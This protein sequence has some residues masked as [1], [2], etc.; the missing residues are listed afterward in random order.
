MG[1]DLFYLS[2]FCPWVSGSSSSSRACCVMYS[3]INLVVVL[4]ENG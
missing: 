3:L 2:T 1:V 4:L